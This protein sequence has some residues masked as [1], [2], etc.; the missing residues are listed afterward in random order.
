VR[1]V[2]VELRAAGLFAARALPTPLH[3]RKHQHPP[4]PPSHQT[5]LQTG[6]FED[7]QLCA[8]HAKRITIFVKDI[9]LARRLRG[10][11]PN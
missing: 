6:L 5:R 9:Q 7:A 10:E 4:N 2:E 3:P 8:I 1:A 11:S